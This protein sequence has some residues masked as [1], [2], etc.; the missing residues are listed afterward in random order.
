MA[1]GTIPGT[2]EKGETYLIRVIDRYKTRFGIDITM[3]W[4]ERESDGHLIA[5]SDRLELLQTISTE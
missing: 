3:Y 2:V 1:I 4:L 5:T